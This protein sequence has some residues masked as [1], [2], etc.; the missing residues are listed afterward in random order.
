[1]FAPHR[2]LKRIFFIR[3]FLKY[4]QDEK[5]EVFVLDEAGKT[6]ILSL[7]IFIGFGTSPFSNYSY[8]P[9]GEKVLKT[10]PKLTKN[11]TCCATISE[12]RVEMLRYFWGGGTKKEIF[13]E[14]FKELL[15][16]LRKKYP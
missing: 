4:I 9:I 16:E 2:K 10:T 14:Y 5:T 7:L 11:V 1:M 12:T 3:E 6:Y 15:K 13:E 8:A